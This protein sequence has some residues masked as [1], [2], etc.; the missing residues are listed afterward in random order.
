MD[1][2]THYNNSSNVEKFNS[3][4]PLLLNLFIPYLQKNCS[5]LYSFNKLNVETP[6]YYNVTIRAIFTF[7]RR[8]KN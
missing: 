3:L 1:K 5:T 6:L 4:I 2:C 8:H 7:H